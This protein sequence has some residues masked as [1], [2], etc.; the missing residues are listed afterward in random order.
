MT[1][2]A[3]KSSNQTKPKPPRR[4]VPRET[5]KFQLRLDDPTDT[6]VAEVLKYAKTR[7]RHVTMLRNG[8]RLMWALENNDLNVLF[9]LF[10]NLKGR[11]IPES[12]DLIEQFRQMLL[13]QRPAE[14]APQLTSGPKPLP[15]PRIAMPTFGQDDDQD[16]VVI[17]RDTASGEQ[18][19]MNFLDA[20]FGFQQK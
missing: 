6:H 4:Y 8:I 17:R 20:A 1:A 5:H 9:E 18:A 11:F 14:I 15:A 12:A 19:A 16:T 10:P 7:R 2:R 13:Q 3:S